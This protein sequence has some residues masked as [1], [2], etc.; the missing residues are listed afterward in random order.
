M[1]DPF[2][3]Y[4]LSL[5]D[6]WDLFCTRVDQQI[7]TYVSKLYRKNQIS[8]NCVRRER[9]ST[10]ILRVII[11][12][13]MEIYIWQ[14]NSVTI[15]VNLTMRNPFH[16]LFPKIK[17]FLWINKIAA[18]KYYAIFSG[19][20]TRW[21]RTTI[22]KTSRA[23]FR[24]RTLRDMQIA[25]EFRLHLVAVVATQ[26]LYDAPSITTRRNLD[27]RDHVRPAGLDR[28]PAA[29]AILPFVIQ[30]RHVPLYSSFFAP[31][32]W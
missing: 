13:T 18:P 32:S 5:Y 6:Q 26:E 30:R 19:Y 1:V 16:R 14:T 8:T 7:E 4:P 31:K 24:G 22:R 21:E 23:S 27:V 11:A 9:K 17:N 20:K 29:I 15:R 2:P 10:F 3:S 12:F 28:P 25:L